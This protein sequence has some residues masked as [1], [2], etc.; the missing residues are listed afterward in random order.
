MRISAYGVAMD[1]PSGWEARIRRH[2]VADQSRIA[3]GGI[4]AERP[5]GERFRAHAVLH[6]ADFVLPEERGDFGSG[7]VETMQ[8]SHAFIALV[9]YDPSS[10]G[11]ALFSPNVGMPR[12]VS[13]DDFSPRQLQRTIR[14]QAGTQIFFVD[15]GRAFCLY[16]VLGSVAN[17]HHV[18]PRVN[19]ILPAIT[20]APRVPSEWAD[21]L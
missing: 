4:E 15:G 21:L 7:A 3:G 1:V 16:V 10:A 14:G 20:I 9:E 11:T 18:V 5:D 2:P 8:P 12:R 17:V 13:T 6:T 19:A